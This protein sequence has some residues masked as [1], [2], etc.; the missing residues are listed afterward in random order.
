MSG[1]AEAGPASEIRPRA[2]AGG[3]P[4]RETVPSGEH[5]S[6]GQALRRQ[7]ARRPDG[8]DRETTAD[9]ATGPKEPRSTVLTPEEEAIE[10]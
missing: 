6:G 9:A 8:R 5:G 4:S 2:H 7:P 10:A 1:A 3:S